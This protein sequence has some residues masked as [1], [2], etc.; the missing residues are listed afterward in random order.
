[1]DSN[2]SVYLQ[3]LVDSGAW[4]SLVRGPGVPKGTIHTAEHNARI[5]KSIERWILEHPEENL[6][7]NRKISKALTGVPRD[8]S[9]SRNC[10]EGQSRR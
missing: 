7:K 1:M 10:S 8:K 3:S 6:E 9:F 5:G 2:L 4:E